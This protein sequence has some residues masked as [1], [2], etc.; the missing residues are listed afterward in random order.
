MDIKFRNL[1]FKYKECWFNRNSSYIF[2]D[3]LDFVEFKDSFCDL[4]LRLMPFYVGSISLTDDLDA[5]FAKFS[6]GFKNEI[7]RAEKEGVYVSF[8]TNSDILKDCLNSYVKF[9]EEKKIAHL[10]QSTL[11]TYLSEN[12]LLVSRAM[13]KEIVIRYHLYIKSS[14]CCSLLASFPSFGLGT[15][16][17]KNFLGWANRFLHWTDM[18]YFK[19][20]GIQSYSLGGIGNLTEAKSSGIAKF[21]HEMTP[22]IECRYNGIVALSLKYKIY[23]FLRRLI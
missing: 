13:H 15:D 4:K 1:F 18:I 8:E 11:E 17:K 10:R 19:N 14:A 12:S 16:Y 9:S 20:V 3:D 2:D 5:I 21:K 7:R 22:E 6:P 23:R